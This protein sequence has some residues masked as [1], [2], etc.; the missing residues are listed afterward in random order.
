MKWLM[1]AAVLALGCEL[2]GGRNDPQAAKRYHAEQDVKPESAETPT[3][4]SAGTVQTGRKTLD[5]IP[6]A[7]IAEDRSSARRAKLIVLVP[8]STTRGQLDDFMAQLY[9]EQMARRDFQN[10][11][12]DGV[13]VH[14]F[15]EGTDWKNAPLQYVG[16]IQKPP[17]AAEPSYENRLMDGS[18]VEQVQSIMSK[19]VSVEALDN[20]GVRVKLSLDEDS[21]LG[22]PLS[23][24]EVIRDMAVDATWAPGELYDRFG[25]LNDLELIFLRNNETIGKVHLDRAKYDNW[26][27]RARIEDI[28]KAQ[29]VVSE[30][31]SA[32][33][34]SSKQADKR[35]RRIDNEGRWD[36]LRAL[37]S[38]SIEFSDK[39][40]P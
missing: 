1:V 23:R 32:G 27:L 35:F 3:A 17:A 6:G 25:S 9:R 29:D 2:S 37:P 16:M 13:H 8:R 38:G 20:N 31:E 28:A 39:Y 22:E 5:I 15:L 4:P 24:E 34:I 19:G 14:F 18:L 36:A 12:P 11:S 10:G 33:R 26:Q 40:V 21:V 7:K 30:A